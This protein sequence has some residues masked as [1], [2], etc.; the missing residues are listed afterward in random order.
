M[1]YVMAAGRMHGEAHL[2]RQRTGVARHQEV[3]QIHLANEGV[4]GSLD[5]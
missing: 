4:K 1:C 2:E 3:G 5:G